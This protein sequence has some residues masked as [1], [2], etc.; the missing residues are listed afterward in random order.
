MTEEEKEEATNRDYH[1]YLEAKGLY[2]EKEGDKEAIAALVLP[3][4]LLPGSRED[5]TTH[6]CV[7]EARA[8]IGTSCLG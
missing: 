6:P 5:K 4:I 8:E 7:E 1:K 3:G 2:A